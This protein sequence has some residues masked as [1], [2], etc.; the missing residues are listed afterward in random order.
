MTYSPAYVTDHFS[1]DKLDISVRREGTTVP[2]VVFSI[3]GRLDYF[4]AGSFHAFVRAHLTKGPVW[5]ALDLAGL[6][7]LAS[8][9]INALVELAD[10]IAQLP[11]DFVLVAVPAS[12]R[13]WMAMLGLDGKLALYTELKDAVEDLGQPQRRRKVRPVFPATVLC[14][15]CGRK[16]QAAKEG[17]FRCATC[18]MPFQVDD[19]GQVRL[20]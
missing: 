7:H 1:G 15:N 11:G 13:Q 4:N 20:L 14:P 5:V 10:D 6:V 3:R 19:R 16:L 9:G 2:I 17:K 8:S 12:I 18:R